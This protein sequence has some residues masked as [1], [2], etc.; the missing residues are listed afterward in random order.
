MKIHIDVEGTPEECA[1]LLRALSQSPVYPVAPSWPL[2]GI[3]WGTGTILQCGAGNPR[4]A[5]RKCTFNPH[6]QGLHFDGQESWQ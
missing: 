1:A 4:D 3:T 6:H 5:T 2:G